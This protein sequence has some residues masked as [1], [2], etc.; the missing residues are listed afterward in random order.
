MESTASKQSP[1]QPSRRWSRAS[2]QHLTAG[3]V[4]RTGSEFSRWHGALCVMASLRFL[5]AVR[6]AAG[7]PSV[8][9]CGT[10]RK[11]LAALG[12]GLRAALPV[13]SAPAVGAGFAP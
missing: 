12:L 7:G 9:A 2:S 4:P 13:R 8:G 6:L 11:P 1:L 10:A 3:P 5:E